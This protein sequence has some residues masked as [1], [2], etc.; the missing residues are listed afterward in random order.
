MA[1]NIIS[2]NLN[3]YGNK[4]AFETDP[5]TWGGIEAYASISQFLTSR[6]ATSPHEGLY[7]WRAEDSGLSVGL[8]VFNT[9]GSDGDL[10][11]PFC[12]GGDHRIASLNNFDTGKKYVARARVKIYAIPDDIVRTDIVKIRPY[13]LAGFTASNFEVTKTVGEVL[14][15]G[16]WMEI[17][18]GWT[19]PSDLAFVLVTILKS[20]ANSGTSLS[21]ST[22]TLTIPTVADEVVNLVVDPALD[23]RAGSI[24]KVYN[25]ATHFFHGS[26]DSYDNS[27]GDLVVRAVNWTGSGNFSSWTVYKYL[28]PLPLGVDKL[29][30]FE[31]EDIVEPCTLLIDVDN[32]DVTDETSGGAN[33]GS[34]DVA[35]T[36]GTGPFEYSKDGGGSWQSSPLFTGLPDGIYTIVVREVDTISCNDTQTFAVNSGAAPGFDFTTT[37]TDESLAG[38]EDGTIE[39]TVTGTGAPFTFSKDGGATYQAGN[40]FSGLA[41]GTY[42]IVVKDSDVLVVAKN[43]TIAAGYAVFEKAWFSRNPV[44]FD[45]GPV[46]TWETEENYRLFDDVR[47]EDVS[48]SGT[49]NSKL[50]VTLYPF[51]DGNVTFQVRQAFRGTLSATPPSLNTNEITRLTD[52][53]KLFKHYTGN[54]FALETT[55]GTLTGS[56]PHLVLLGGLNKFSWAGSDYF[57]SFLPTTKK[58]MTWAPVE[59]QVDRNQEDYLNFFVYALSTTTLKLRIKAYF[60]DNTN[61]TSTVMT[62]VGVAYGQLFQVPAGPVNAGVHLITPAKTVTK[63]EL[64]LTD[65]ADAVISE[66]RT[67]RLDAVTHPRRR[68][69]MFLNSLGAFEVLRFTGSAS[70]TTEV[71]K[72][73]VVKFLPVDYAALD[74]ETETFGASLR[75][76]SSFSS[77]YFDDR[78]AAAWLDYMKDF[79]LSRQVYE[80]TDGKRRPINIAGGLYPTG[81][82]Q[83]YTRFIRFTALD[84]YEDD[85]YTPKDSGL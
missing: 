35:I 72:E 45:K 31:Y 69:F 34:I 39:V 63:Y 43:V 53:I 81:A 76:G 40:T 12:M 19:S 13:G 85:S 22:S 5:T 37:K 29:E 17:E 79:L 77:G 49:F 1:Y 26:V 11:M 73:Q 68:L 21:D 27:T 61:T 30:I 2:A 82:D 47:V 71:T 16:G 28:F 6:H 56:N 10:Q 41:P 70:M 84:S 75:E 65:Q 51:G 42:T 15:D 57:G 74:G 48:G 8:V 25:D 60:D 67:Y 14:D 9:T 59:K 44:T 58:F 52:R 46:P 24:V 54:L 66:V 20:S 55:P 7:S 33:D 3:R 4:G 64:W 62:K 32:T 50:K 83:D 80:V 36:G 18:T 23:I 78:L 38:A